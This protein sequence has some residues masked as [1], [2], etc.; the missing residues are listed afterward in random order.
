MDFKQMQDAM[1]RRQQNL[2]Q[3]QFRGVPVAKRQMPLVPA[4]T[5]F[6]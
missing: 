1:K 4:V 6:Q 5:A 2:A 3:P